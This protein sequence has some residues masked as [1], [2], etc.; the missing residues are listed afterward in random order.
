MATPLCQPPDPHPR[1][2]RL[3]APAGTTDTHF[4]IL[5][6]AA[7]YAYVAERDYTP[8]DALAADAARL[9]QIL[10][11]ER[12]VL[13]QPSVFGEDNSCMIDAAAE[14]PIPSRLIVAA[15]ADTPDSQ[16]RRLHEAGARGVRFILAH[17]GGVPLVE[18]EPLTE[19]VKDMGWHCQFLLRPAHIV[20]L[21]RRFASLQVDY[22][23][24]H[25]G[26]IRPSDGGAAQPAFQALLRMME[27]GRCWVK[28]TGGY[29]ISSEA[30]PY[31]DVA[32]LAAALVER[33]PDR[34]LWGSDWPHVMVKG[35]MPNTTELL[36]LLLD[37][38]PNENCRQQILVD[39]PKR[40]FQF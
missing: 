33:F 37:W 14:L 10:G 36:D 27:S 35:A 9:F 25:I 38:V 39:N 28:L 6:P 4:H 23:V 13:V 30:P 12:A 8:P 31:H 16:L 7:K 17:P 15:R 3:R 20:E 18:L 22:V 34:L 1:P 11:V 21:E 5:G 40:L 2:P 29:R 24:D 26:L 19:R 32:P